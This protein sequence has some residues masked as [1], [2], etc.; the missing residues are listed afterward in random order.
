MNKL[1]DR[2]YDLIEPS[3]R[4]L[5]YELVGVEYIRAGA[6]S[7]LRVFIDSSDGISVDDCETVSRQVST[8]LDVEDPVSGQYT[9]EVSSPG[10]DRPFFRP[11]Q[12][13]RFAGQRIKV[14]TEEPLDG[15]RTFHGDLIEYRDGHLVLDDG[16]HELHIPW[17]SVGR[18]NLVPEF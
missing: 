11:E 18:A 4:A 10:L 2:L 7:V 14:R 13:E 5:G 6:K 17:A 12:F 15:Q 9:L 3:A 1:N 16:S 8:V